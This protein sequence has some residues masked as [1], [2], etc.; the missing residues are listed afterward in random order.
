MCLVCVQSS[1]LSYK[2]VYLLKLLDDSISY[3][4]LYGIQSELFFMLFATGWLKSVKMQ[5]NGIPWKF[6][7]VRFT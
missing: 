4:L 5:T 3:E 6:L 7:F 1:L 2:P